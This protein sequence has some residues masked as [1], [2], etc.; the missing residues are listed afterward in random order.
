MSLRGGGKTTW[1]SFFFEFSLRNSAH[2]WRNLAL[3]NFN[4]YVKKRKRAKNRKGE[5]TKSSK[6][7][8]KF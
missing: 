5:L 3:K 2:S 1:Q 6:S 7:Q 4:Y 8:S